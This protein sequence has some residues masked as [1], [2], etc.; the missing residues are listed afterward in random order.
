MTHAVTVSRTRRSAL[1]R[2]AAA[3]CP[4]AAEPPLPQPHA[5]VAAAA[6]PLCPHAAAHPQPPP[7]VPTAEA[8]RTRGGG[9]G[10]CPAVAVGALKG[11]RDVPGPSVWSFAGDLLF[12]RGLSRLHEL[13]IEGTRRYGPVWKAQFGPFVTVHV[14]CA[15]LMEQV[16]RQE[17]A[18]PIRSELSSW[19]D[20][21]TERGHAFG[22]LTA[23]GEEWQ[24]LRRVIGDR[25]LKPGRAAAY[26]APLLDVVGDLLDNVERQRTQNQGL[27]RDV[28][29]VFYKF[30]LEGIGAVLFEARLGCLAPN[31]PEDTERFI[32]AINSMFQLTLLTMA[33]PRPLLWLYPTPWKR[34]VAAWDCLFAFAKT[35]ID[36]R[37]AE[38]SEQTRRGEAVQERVL[39]YYLSRQDLSMRQIYGNLT[40]LLLAGVDTISSTMSW[41][42]YEVSRHA[43]LQ[44]RLHAEVCAAMGGRATPGPDEL[45]R[46]PL[47]RATVKEALR[48]YPV[49]PGNA[50]VFSQRDVEIGEYLIPR[51]TLIT[52]CHYA[53][54]HDERYFPEPEAFR[55][56]R[57]LDKGNKK[58]GEEGM[59]S[60][61]SIPFGFGKRSC[62][63]RRLAELEVH[64]A[65]A[66][67]IK[68]YV[69]K[70]ESKDSVVRPMT[71]TLLVPDRPINLRFLNR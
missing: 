19:K 9:G 58:E 12:R 50:R 61:A 45:A 37:L 60:F 21:R 14:A 34:F 64:L 23:E 70:P 28:S 17:G 29:D 44:E 52:L 38:L 15:K 32:Q 36:S 47:L 11:L 54:S 10:A 49:I 6:A 43:D 18:H 26:T 33:M 51:G 65:L 67:I 13:Q 39:A 62:V 2:A 5:A 41:S 40:E 53:T 66:Q 27:V 56:D 68:K 20:Y 31:V 4:H 63:G 71:R 3:L 25:M 42:L 55:P 69:I 7:R 57:W 1:W 8:Q 48:L 46:M 59:H 24:R 16:L 22:L 30:G 35:H